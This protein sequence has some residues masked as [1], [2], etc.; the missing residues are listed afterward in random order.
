MYN[1]VVGFQ[2]LIERSVGDLPKG[3]LNLHLLCH[4]LSQ[5]T[6]TFSVYYR[7]IRILTV[8]VLASVFL[9]YS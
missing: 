1:F 5:L 6:A 4:F 3:I 9:A 2:Y 7:R 8:I